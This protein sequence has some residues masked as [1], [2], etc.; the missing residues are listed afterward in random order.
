MKPRRAGNGGDPGKDGL[1]DS[2]RVR[3]GTADFLP[4]FVALQEAVRE[5]CAL[6]TRWEAQ[7]VAGIKAALEF[8]AAHPAQ[9]HA[10]IVVTRQEEDGTPASRSS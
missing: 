2:A 8:G 9:A 5:A 7:I 4:S 6:Q 10:L 1:S 3:R